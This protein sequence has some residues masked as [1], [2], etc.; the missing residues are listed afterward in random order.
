MIFASIFVI[1]TCY[2][3]IVAAQGWWRPQVG[4]TW[5][6]QIDGSGQIDTSIVAD[7]FDVDLV[8]TDQS[9]ID[10]L[11]ALVRRVV[12]YMSVG[13]FENYAADAAKF[14]ASVI[15][16]VYD[17]YPNERWLDVRR[18]DILLPIMRARMDLCKAKRFD[19]VEPDN[20]MIYDVENSGFT[21]T[22]EENLKY[23]RMLALEAHA[24]G[25]AI[26]I[27]NSPDDLPD[28]IDHFD[29]AVVEDFFHE[30]VAP[31][32]SAMTAR[33]KPVFAVEYSHI[34]SPQLFMNTYCPLA[35]QLRYNLILKEQGV[36]AKRQGCPA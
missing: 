19:A 24:R 3:S 35:K 18:L 34:V 33:G 17:G 21:I 36:T 8:G 14:P 16:S 26:G 11:H 22:K 20:M 32:Y 1:C 4:N 29:F 2:S 15:G 30:N 28:L 6:Y 25:L 27:K 12:C 10:R 7:V 9:V 23:V 13:S 31:N 5:Q